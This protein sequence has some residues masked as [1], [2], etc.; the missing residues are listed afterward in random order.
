MRVLVLAPRVAQVGKSSTRQPHRVTPSSRWCA[1]NR[2]AAISSPRTRRG[3]CSRRRRALP[4]AP[5]LR[6]SD[7]LDWHAHEPVSRSDASFRRNASA[8][9]GVGQAQGSPF[10]VHHRLRRRRQPRA[11]RFCFRHPGAA[12]AAAEGLPRQGSARGDHPRQRS[13]LGASPTHGP[14]RQ[15]RHGRGARANRS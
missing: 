15:T 8:G 14:E 9:E 2:K 7:Q 12:V 5:G 11:R 4:R 6:R 3:R 1:P 10:G 13:R